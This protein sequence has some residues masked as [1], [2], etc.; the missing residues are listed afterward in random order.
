MNAAFNSGISTNMMRDAILGHRTDNIYIYIKD[1]NYAYSFLLHASNMNVCI[2]SSV[3]VCLQWPGM[4]RLFDCVVLAVA[5][6]GD[7][8]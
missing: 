6:D 2:L 1:V 5:R 3:H 8:V 4:V 7:T